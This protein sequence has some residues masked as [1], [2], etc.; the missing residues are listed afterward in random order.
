MGVLLVQSHSPLWQTGLTV[1]LR[2]SKAKELSSIRGV[3]CSLFL[4][5]EPLNVYSKFALYYDTI[6]NEIVDY[7]T[8]ASFLEKVFEK[9]HMGKVTSILD[10]GCGTGNY[11]F[12]FVNRGYQATRIDLSRDMIEVARKKI[13]EMR[14]GTSKFPDFF[15]MDM[16]DIRLNFEENNPSKFDVVSNLFGG[17]GYLLNNDDV[18]KFFNSARAHLNSRGLLIFEFWH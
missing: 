4:G 14:K 15:E 1:F 12:A 6:Y 10:V 8:Q 11:T 9:F 2:V 13:S 7:E 5:K 16:R 17:F 3:W 18:L